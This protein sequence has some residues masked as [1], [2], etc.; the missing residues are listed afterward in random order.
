RTPRLSGNSP[1]PHSPA[2]FAIVGELFGS[3]VGCTPEARAAQLTQVRREDPA[4]AIDVSA[5]LAAHVAAEGF[6]ESPI[7]THALTWTSDPAYPT[8]TTSNPGDVGD[9]V[10]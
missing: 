4:L 7:V 5:L 6:L 8:A 3:L 9:L 2:R 10:S 1:M